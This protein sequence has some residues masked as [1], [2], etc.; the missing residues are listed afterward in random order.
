[1]R[2]LVDFLLVVATVV[3]CELAGLR[4]A[5]LLGALS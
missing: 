1:M 2:T 5:H 3:A 4:V